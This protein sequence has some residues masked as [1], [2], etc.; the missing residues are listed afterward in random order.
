[1]KKVIKDESLAETDNA[2]KDAAVRWNAKNGLQ[3]SELINRDIRDAF[4]AGAEWQKEQITKDA[5]ESEIGITSGGIL[6]R[7]LRIEDFDYED[8]VKIIIV[9]QDA[10][11]RK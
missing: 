10:A 2:L 4:I 8:K 3:V 6:L 5:V 11:R 9:K 1:M 7:D